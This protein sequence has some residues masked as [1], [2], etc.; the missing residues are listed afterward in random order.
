MKTRN[1]TVASALSSTYLSK[2]SL[3][4]MK[5]WSFWQAYSI[6]SAWSSMPWFTPHGPGT[7]S[8]GETGPRPQ[9]WT[10]IGLVKP[11]CSPRMRPTMVLR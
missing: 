8:T 4:W 5:E 2:L 11:S 7:G 3:V 9:T 10:W 1:L 6:T